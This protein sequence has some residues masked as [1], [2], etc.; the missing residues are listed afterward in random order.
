MNWKP[1]PWIAVI[2]SIL[3]APFGLV[4]AGQLRLAL[5][6]VVILF[7]LGTIEFFQLLGIERDPLAW[8]PQYLAA[9]A[10]I[11][12]AY[13]TAKASP[14]RTQPWYSRWYGLVG[15]GGAV[16]LALFLFRAFLY[17][18]FR[19]P[20]TAM[21][22]TVPAGSRIIVQKFGYGHYTAYGMRV[23][24]P[25]PSAPLKRGD[26]IVFDHPGNPAD[27]YVKR[28]VGVPGDQVVYRD[29]H[30]F[31][32]GHDSR[33]GKMDDYLLPDM[34]RSLQHFRERLDDTEFETLADNDKPTGMVQP[35]D[36]KLRERCVYAAGE[37]RCAVPAGSYFVLG[38]N[39]DNSFDSRHWGFVRSDLVVGKVVKVIR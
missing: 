30:L 24:G 11:I 8:L 29:K 39:R 17:E 2:L 36:F 22:P 19:I 9:I 21:S 38:D 6:F 10:A 1:N 16:L 14:A 4:Y 23:S 37:M 7:S 13:R 35:A 32:N 18:P 5:L 27:V 31:V 12:L 26:I 3:A 15:I 25:P 20:S 28:I 33:I 34:P